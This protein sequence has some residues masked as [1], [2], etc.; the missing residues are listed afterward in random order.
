MR[1]FS[2]ILILLT[3]ALMPAG[4][5]VDQWS[6]AQTAFNRD[7]DRLK[8][9]E[10]EDAA[11]KKA[12]ELRVQSNRLRSGAIQMLHTPATEELPDGMYRAV[13]RLRLQGMLHSLGAGI[14]LGIAEAPAKGKLGKPFQKRIVYPNEFQAEDEYQEF[15]VDFDI[16]GPYLTRYHLDKDG[17]A[18]FLQT[19]AKQMSQLP[20]AEREMIE[21]HLRD[22]PGT[23]LPE[24]KNKGKKKPSRGLHNLIRSINRRGAR[25]R[26]VCLT[27]YLPK[28]TPGIGG[29][30]GN[31]T[32]W[33]SIR[34]LYADTLRIERLTEGPMTIR[35]FQAQYAW[36]RPGE[37]QRFHVKLHNRSGK[38]QKAEL[39]LRVMHGLTGETTIPAPA[40]ELANGQ[41]RQL[42]VEWII[43]KNHPMWGQEAVL[44]VMVGGKAVVTART[45]FSL[46]QRNTAVM[47]PT[48]G[49]FRSLESHRWAHPTAAKPNVANHEEFWAPTPYDSAGLVPDDPD[50]PFLRGN[51]GQLECL[52]WQAERAKANADRGIASVFYLEGHGTGL[53]AW[54]L[55]F[56][57]PDQVSQGM[58]TPPSDL[59]LLKRMEAKKKIDAW[60][61]GGG[62]GKHPQYPHVGFVMFNGFYKEVVDRVIKGHIAIM[63][64]VPYTT[65]R[66]DSSQP[67][68]AYGR[69]ILGRDLGKTKAELDAVS[70]ANIKRY[71][72]EVRAAHPHFEVGLNWNHGELMNKPP[73]PF[74]FAAARAV[75]DKDVICKM[76]LKDQG[77]LLEEAWGHSFENWNDYKYTCR[78]YL[79]ANRYEDAA[80][81]YAGGHHGHMFRD[82]AVQYTPDDIYQQTF[83]LLG[84]AHMCYVNYGPLPDSRYDLGVYATRFSEFFWDPALKPLEHIEDKLEVDTDADIWT[85]EAG[86]EK[87]TAAGTRI[88]VLP[89][90]NPPVTEKWLK[91]RYG[92]LPEPIREPIPML[93]HIPE[94][95]SK[96]KGVYHLENS[97]YPTVK[98]LTFDAADGE[99]V[100]ELPE[101]VTFEVV[102]VEFAK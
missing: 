88:Y 9:V 85:T 80:Y 51:S 79:R 50:K 3:A 24:P 5:P 27:V 63:N 56:D 49:K 12:L 57:N 45:W 33:P 42:A 99:V 8:L 67:M 10:D 48:G 11:D 7:S 81:K 22:H 30:R 82:M 55:Y 47:I 26:K 65:C 86:Y 19:Y 18:R 66:W 28:S 15:T 6:A 68:K 20:A 58:Y 38:P 74:D 31:S 2:I 69:D 60:V 4:E 70:V 84:G 53:R 44:D 101:L 61:K 40:V 77:Y 102:V 96:A 54:D 37:T 87:D 29:S 16:S 92:L 94:G 52:R 90:I 76:V 59:F 73:D 95:Y 83:S 89:I 78:N 34:R 39:R 71:L 46:H 13:F 43:P 75:I 1:V 21:N 14:V 91:N 64:E 100:F 62:K 17:R 32:P 97:P 41:Y 72:K 93:V 25:P 35:D 23:L 36:R 98:P